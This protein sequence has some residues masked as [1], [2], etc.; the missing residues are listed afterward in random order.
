MLLGEKQRSGS[1]Y[2]ISSLWSTFCLS[3]RGDERHVALGRRNQCL[4]P[5]LWPLKL[6]H[7]LILSQAIQTGFVPTCLRLKSS[8][9]KAFPSVAWGSPREERVS[10]IQK[11]MS[12]F[13]WHST[14]QGCLT[15]DFSGVFLK[16]PK[17]TLLIEFVEYLNMMFLLRNLS[18]TQTL[19]TLASSLYVVMVFRMVVL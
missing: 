5:K 15:S 19:T 1:S 9:S 13:G 17:F 16:V 14:G 7:I 2:F 4:V 8:F 3:G 6:R 12:V 10:P 11:L 18:A